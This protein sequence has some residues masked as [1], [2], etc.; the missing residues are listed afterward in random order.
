[1]ERER[2]DFHQ[3]LEFLAQRAGV[4]LKLN[5]NNNIKSNK[6]NNK[7]SLYD[8]MSLA[9]RYF[10]NNLKSDGTAQAYLAR[11]NLN[12]NQAA[13]FNL[14]WAPR[15][16][17]GLLKFLSSRGVSEAQALSA[18]LIIASERGGFY[19][20]FRGRIMFPVKDISGR[21]I[22]FGGRLVD[23]EGAKYI[24]SP[25]GEIYSKRSNLYLI[26]QA[27]NFMKTC[28]RAILVEGYMDAL[29]LH[30][31]GFNETVASLGTSLTEEQ[32]RLIKRFCDTCYICYDSDEAGQEAALRGMYILQSCGLDVRVV[33]I[34]VGKDPDELLSS[35]DGVNLFNQALSNAQPLVLHHLAAIKKYLNDANKRRFGVESLLNGLAQLEP[36]DIA[37]YLYNLTGALNL[38]PENLWHEIKTRK[39]KR[40]TP[41]PQNLNSLNNDN[42]NLN[43]FNELECALLALLWHSQELRRSII[44]E[45]IN[46]IDE[47]MDLNKLLELIDPEHEDIADMLAAILTE[48]PDILEERWLSLNET[49][50]LSLISRGDEFLRNIPNSISDIK[51]KFDAICSVLKAR[52]LTKR[53]NELKLKLNSGSATPDELMEY[54]AAAAKIKS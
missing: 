31:N 36:I 3:A 45:N 49:H 46:I 16:W 27:K 17:D 13:K 50:Y 4:E 15:A 42:N 25:E 44:D 28:G 14:G 9:S 10:E 23:G 41:E 22:A 7:A 1:M 19:D 52:K 2:M 47:N 48:G 29:R 6:S 38:N 39:R 32:A 11:R 24:N 34:A 35:P 54:C 43:N 30:L 33:K 5:I 21:V 53:F 18:G 8:I 12:L 40:H 26:D 51:A 20:R 37:P